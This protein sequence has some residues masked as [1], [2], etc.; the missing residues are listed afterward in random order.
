MGS[1][2]IRN[3]NLEV[4]KKTITHSITKL[5]A[6]ALYSFASTSQSKV[7]GQNIGPNIKSLLRTENI[8]HRL[9]ITFTAQ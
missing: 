8:K 4:Y 1:G 6:S 3:L 7:R 2:F 5:K 9:K